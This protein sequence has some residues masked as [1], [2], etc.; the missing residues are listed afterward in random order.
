MIE[1]EQGSL[2]EFQP[3]VL[4]F[5]FSIDSFR[6]FNGRETVKAKIYANGNVLQ[7]EHELISYCNGKPV[8]LSI[9]LLTDKQAHNSSEVFTHV[10]IQINQ[11]SKSALFE[12]PKLSQ[13]EAETFIE[14]TDPFQLVLPPSLPNIKNGDII[15]DSTYSKVLQITSSNWWNDKRRAVLGWECNVRPTQP[16]EVYSILPKRR[17]IQSQNSVVINR[18]NITKKF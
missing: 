4:P 16:Q 10:E 18:P 5:A 2:I 13:S 8:V 17:T 11:S 14:R 7:S 1:P 3:V 12:F 6:V 9:Q 15:V